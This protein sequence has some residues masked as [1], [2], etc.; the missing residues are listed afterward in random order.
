MSRMYEDSVLLPLKYASEGCRETVVTVVRKKDVSKLVRMKLLPSFRHGPNVLLLRDDLQS[1]CRVLVSMRKPAR[2]DSQLIPIDLFG[3]PLPARKRTCS[4]INLR[5][6]TTLRLP[7]KV[8]F[9]EFQTPCYFAAVRNLVSMSNEPVDADG[10][11]VSKPYFIAAIRTSSRQVQAL[12]DKQVRL[13]DSI[14]RL[15]ASQFANSAY[16]MGCKRN[17]AGFLVEAI[18]SVLPRDGVVVDLMCG[19]GAASAAFARVWR[20]FASDSLRFCRILASIQGAGFSVD[21]AQRILDDMVPKTRDHM[22]RLSERLSHFVET[23][24]RLLHSNIDEN[25]LEEY[26]R[27]GHMLPA[28]GNGN[29]SPA[30]DPLREVEI[31]KRNSKTEPYCLFTSYFANIYFSLRQCIEIDS[32]RFAIDQIENEQ[33]KEWALGALLAAMSALGTT[34]AGHFAQPVKLQQS[35][36]AKYLERRAMS[37]THEFSFRL[38]S[39]SRESE[40]S[41]HPV[42]SV[43]G[44]W[45]EALPELDQLLSD[46]KVVVYVDAPYKRE[47]YSRYY[48]VLETAV[49]YNYPSCTGKGRMPDIR[50]KERFG[51]VFATRDEGALHRAFVKVITDVL[52]RGWTCAWSYSDSARANIVEVINDVCR[53]TSCKVRSYSTPYQHQP[54]G[55]RRHLKRV[56]EYLILFVPRPKG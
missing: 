33:A 48:H 29:S 6:D 52:A 22:A 24:D 17:L 28:Y 1:F 56:T 13:A 23:E 3:K 43:E 21:D 19:S 5:P 18:S 7:E 39:L 8:E 31:R 42:Q 15:E 10:G 45:D 50:N 47:D 40:K 20:T 32:L 41:T 54:Q 51:S 12:V 9:V 44:P 35:N 34:Y 46:E 2:S 49:L 55:K 27:F 30:W 38:L 16:Y 11:V 37:V 26:Q 4:E 53:S 14:R 25:L 36:I